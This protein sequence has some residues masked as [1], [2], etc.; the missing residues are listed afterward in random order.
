MLEAMGQLGPFSVDDYQVVMIYTG[1]NV[2]YL[3]RSRPGKALADPA[4]QIRKITYDGDNATVIQFANGVN[5]YIHPATSVTVITGYDY[6]L[7]APA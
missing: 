4:W 3:C 2:T 5:D 7:I 6:T 1:A